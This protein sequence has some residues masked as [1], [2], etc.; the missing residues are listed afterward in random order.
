MDD[1][2]FADFLDI[3]QIHLKRPRTRKCATSAL[4]PN[5]LKKRGYSNFC[6]GTGIS[7]VRFLSLLAMVSFIVGRSRLVGQGRI[8]SAL[9]HKMH[10]LN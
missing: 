7:V 3:C 2:P 4:R 1:I 10:K 5:L 9:N 6:I 8:G